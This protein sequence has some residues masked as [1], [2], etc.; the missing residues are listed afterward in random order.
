MAVSKPP[1]CRAYRDLRQALCKSIFLVCFFRRPGDVFVAAGVGLALAAWPFVIWR[2][3]DE[4]MGLMHGSH[5]PPSISARSLVALC[6]VFIVASL[7]VIVLLDAPWQIWSHLKKLRMSK[8]D[9]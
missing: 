1:R 3:H 4:M 6:C 2:Y 8:E 9:V 7:L 5:R